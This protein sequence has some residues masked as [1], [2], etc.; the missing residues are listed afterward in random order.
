MGKKFEILKTNWK[1][2]KSGSATQKKT[3]EIEFEIFQK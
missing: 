2:L 3:V 1:L